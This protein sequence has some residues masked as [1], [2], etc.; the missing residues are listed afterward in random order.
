MQDGPDYHGTKPNSVSVQGQDAD[1]NSTG[2]VTTTSR[3][4]DHFVK[5]SPGWQ[6]N[7]WSKQDGAQP[8]GMSKFYD[9]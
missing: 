3:N 4:Y 8:V 6:L 5:V 7:L 2:Q 9:S 1:G